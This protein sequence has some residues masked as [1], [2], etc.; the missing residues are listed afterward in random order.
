MITG[1]RRLPPHYVTIRVPWHDGGWNGTV[2]ALPLDN[3]SSLIL[4]AS[5][6][7]GATK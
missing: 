5:A 3:S 7:A 1:A 6:R 2:C 4:C